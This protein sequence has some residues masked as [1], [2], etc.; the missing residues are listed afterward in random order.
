MFLWKLL[1]GIPEL[2]TP[3]FW[4]IGKCHVRPLTPSPREPLFF[5]VPSDI[6]NSIL[7]R[8]ACN[9]TSQY[10]VESRSI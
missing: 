3:S 8:V 5:Y 6:N 10:L 2:I 4:F 7:E 1:S 9:G